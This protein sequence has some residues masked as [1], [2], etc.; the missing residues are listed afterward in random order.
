MTPEGR[1]RRLS[2]HTLA[3]CVLVAAAAVGLRA[4]ATAES[5]YADARAREQAVRAALTS[6]YPAATVLK[7]VHGVVADYEALV[8][9]GVEFL[10][11]PAERPYGVEAV[12]RDDS[13]NWFSFTQRKAM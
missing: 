11:P 13:G 8:E 7:A 5:L 6:D 1:V 3:M 10:Q 4:A 9:R 2:A 12:M